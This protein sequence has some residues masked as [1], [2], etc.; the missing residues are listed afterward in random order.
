MAPDPPQEEF[1]SFRHS[2]LPAVAYRNGPSTKTEVHFNSFSSLIGR[3][4]WSRSSNERQQQ[5]VQVI[6][7]PSTVTASWNWVRFASSERWISVAEGRRPV[8][9]QDPGPI[10]FLRSTAHPTQSYSS[11]PPSIS[12]NRNTPGRS[13]SSAILGTLWAPSASND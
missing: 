8:D 2:Q 7:R 3:N 4:A 13:G 9:G 10:E 5:S 6:P 1:N 11:G 12:P